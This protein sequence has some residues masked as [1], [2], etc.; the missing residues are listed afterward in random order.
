[1]PDGSRVDR[2]DLGV[3]LAIAGAVFL[4]ASALL[5]ID[6]PERLNAVPINGSIRDLPDVSRPA[7]VHHGGLPLI[8]M[9]V[10][11]V[12]ALARVFLGR[13]PI[14]AGWPAVLFATGAAAWIGLL[15]SQT[16]LRT[17]YR[18]GANGLPERSHS[19]VLGLGIAGYVAGAGAVLAFVGTWL[20]QRAAP[21]RP[22]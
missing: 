6:E 11:I 17:L 5:P 4:L 2:L 1:M 22:L 9:A 13:P 7:F 15:V 21:R 19:V 12:V 14:G 8:L 16:S 20:V 10:C 3:V 18:L